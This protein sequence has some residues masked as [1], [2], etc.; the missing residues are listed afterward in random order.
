MPRELSR[1]VTIQWRNSSKFL[2]RSR[3]IFRYDTSKSVSKHRS[4]DLRQHEP[5]VTLNTLRYS[6]FYHI[7]V[8]LLIPSDNFSFQTYAKNKYTVMSR[9]S[10]LNV[11]ITVNFIS[12]K[13]FDRERHREVKKSSKA[14]IV[15]SL[16]FEIIYVC[17]FKVS[18]EIFYYSL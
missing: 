4:S 7:T 18:T 14:H 5:S 10:L 12:L 17:Q 13:K 3:S 11:N 8:S 6:Q 9:Y 16:K 2:D 1:S 15:K